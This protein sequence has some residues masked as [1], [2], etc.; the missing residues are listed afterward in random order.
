MVLANIEQCRVEGMPLVFTSR[1]GGQ[2]DVPFVE[3]GNFKG[4]LDLGG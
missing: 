2:R 4:C 3:L 1:S